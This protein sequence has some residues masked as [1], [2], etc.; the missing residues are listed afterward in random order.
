MKQGRESVLGGS[1]REQRLA[2]G[3]TQ[4]QLATT[5]DL[6]LTAVRDLEQGVTRSPHGT[7]RSKLADALGL[8]L[9]SLSAMVREH[10]LLASPDVAAG[11]TLKMRVLGP[12]AVWTGSMPLP[13]GSA[14]Q[15]T[16]LA[17]LALNPGQLIHRDAM[18][19]L[20]WQHDPPRTASTMIQGA[21]S[22]IRRA[23]ALANATS[24]LTTNGTRYQLLPGPDQLDLI[25][26]A[27]LAQA[28]TAARR[29]GD[30]QAA[31]DL[32]EQ[33]LALWT[34][35][36][37]A[38]IDV[39]QASP[40]L[41]A[42]RTRHANLV[43]DYADD[44]S[45]QGNHAQVLPHLH[46]LTGRDPFDER[47]HACLMIAIA[48]TGNQAAALTTY[49][50]IRRHLDDRL[51]LAPGQILRVAQARVLRGDVIPQRGLA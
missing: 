16:V 41:V 11:S 51:G 44:A 27:R 19:D 7:T 2:L 6:S 23:F 46:A 15:R 34:D 5:A 29:Q 20:I 43:A 35:D 32:Y 28:A 1:I 38:D 21:V 39:L 12:L 40:L 37:V 10:G 4:R 33:A 22:R 14:R 50:R 31:W 18:S 48:G 42:L 17:I 45:G 47:A 13:L 9:H 8:E 49:D 25:A 30:H 24:V 26:Y 36:P 3:L